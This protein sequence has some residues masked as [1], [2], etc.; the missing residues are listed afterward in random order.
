M[1]NPHAVFLVP[2]VSAVPLEEVGPRVEG[3]PAFPNRTNAEFVQVLA[4][5]RLRVRVW[6]RG[7]GATLACGTGACAAHAAARTHGRAAERAALELPGGIL[8]V[9]WPGPGAESVLR[10]PAV[11]VFDGTWPLGLLPP[12]RG[13]RVK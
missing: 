10:G 9:T 6:E 11:R 1:G 4:P 5:N 12:L 13:E 7:A 2:D 3:H 8:T